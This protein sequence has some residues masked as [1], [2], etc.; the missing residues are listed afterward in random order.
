MP[1]QYR[2]FHRTDQEVYTVPT[3]LKLNLDYLPVLRAHTVAEHEKEI[4]QTIV[5][6]FLSITNLQ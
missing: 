2:G 3:D 6:L 1:T 5:N 4:F